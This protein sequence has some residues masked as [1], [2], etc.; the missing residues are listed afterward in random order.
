MSNDAYASSEVPDTSVV[1]VDLSIGDPDNYKIL[2]AAFSSTTDPEHAKPVPLFDHEFLE[3]CRTVN[4]EGIQFSLAAFTNIEKCIEYLKEN[5]HRKIFL[6]TSA[7]MGRSLLP[8]IELHCR[9]VF[10]DQETNELCACVYVFCHD[11]TRH[12]DWMMD[13]IDYIPTTFTFDKDLLVRLVHDIANY[14]RIKSIRLLAKNPRDYSVIKSHLNWAFILYQRYYE[15][16]KIGLK[17]QVNEVK[18][19]LNEIEEIVKEKEV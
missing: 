16:D 15:L 3:I 5:R 8:L 2:K 10:T 17:E 11:A 1:W 4:F 6:I 7:S 14:F 19:L 13:Y 12:I 9:N 18:R